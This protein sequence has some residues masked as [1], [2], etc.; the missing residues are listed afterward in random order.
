MRV[1]PLSLR[2]ARSRIPRAFVD[3]D[4]DDDPVGAG[5][6]RRGQHLPDQHERPPA[7]SLEAREPMRALHGSG[8]IA[9][10]E[11]GAALL[12]ALLL[13]VVLTALRI[14]LLALGTSEVPMS[15]NW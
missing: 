2:R 15:S 6:G 5:V 7:E 4:S 14:P 12:I 11:R 9:S 3:F 10:S 13:L 8:T 1:T